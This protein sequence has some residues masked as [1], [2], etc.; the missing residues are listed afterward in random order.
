MT[1]LIIYNKTLITVLSF[2]LSLPRQQPKKRLAREEIKRL[3]ATTF[4]CGR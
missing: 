4:A 1:L 2:H 3:S